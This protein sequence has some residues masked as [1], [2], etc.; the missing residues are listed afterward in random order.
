MG[1]IDQLLHHGR[2]GEMAGRDPIG[3]C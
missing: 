2:R 3:V 1:P